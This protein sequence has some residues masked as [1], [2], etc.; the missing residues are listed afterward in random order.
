[1]PY[2]PIP[3]FLWNPGRIIVYSLIESFILLCT[4]I[5]VSPLAAQTFFLLALPPFLLHLQLPS[6]PASSPPFLFPSPLLLPLAC[7]PDGGGNHGA[8]P[9]PPWTCYV[10]VRVPHLPRPV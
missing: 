2:S 10:P 5:I 1:M 3:P 4:S 7:G 9:V 8:F 6:A